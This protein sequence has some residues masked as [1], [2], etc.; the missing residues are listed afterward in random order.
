[1]RFF[2]HSAEVR[3]ISGMSAKT[4]RPYN[5]REQ[6]AFVQL[7]GCP[8]PLP[9][10][11]RLEDDEAPYEPGIYM[12]H[13]DSHFVDRFRHLQVRARL[14]RASRQPLEQRPQVARAVNG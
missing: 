6:E 11:I 14:D 13:S 2:V 3:V 7:S 12:L 1:M 4:G 9:V 10:N 8:Y 5:I